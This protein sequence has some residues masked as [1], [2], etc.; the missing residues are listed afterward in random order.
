MDEK[1]K[2]ITVFEAAGIEGLD[3]ETAIARF[4]GNAKIYAKIINTFVDSIGAHLDALA[5]LAPEGLDAYAIT[6]HGVKGSLYGV[7]ANREGDMA[8]EL[9]ISA[10]GGDFEKVAAGNAPFIRAVKELAV[11]FGK[12][13]AEI[14]AGGAG[15]QKKPEPDKAL[16]AAM[17]DASRDWDAEKMQ[18]TQ[19]ELEKFEYDNG[20]DLVAWLGEQVTAFC[21]NKIEERLVEI[22]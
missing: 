11:K 3:L 18:E 16:L 14:E 15:G 6:V 10:K 5:G 17:L 4:G 12:A 2:I 13:L 1:E 21:Y 22:I 9:E 20:G 7:S 19:K 8:K